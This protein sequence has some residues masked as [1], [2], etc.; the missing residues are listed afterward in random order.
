MVGLRAGLSLSIGPSELQYSVRDSRSECTV[1][2][3]F[4]QEPLKPSVGFEDLLV[5]I[6]TRG[7]IFGH[8]AKKMILNEK[9]F[10][11]L[12]VRSF[13]RRKYNHQTSPGLS[14]ILIIFH[15]LKSMPKMFSV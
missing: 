3:I 5:I 13:N 15:S 1:W 11:L 14:E 12:S 6:T 7:T 10:R 2:F 4:A 8:F 9:M